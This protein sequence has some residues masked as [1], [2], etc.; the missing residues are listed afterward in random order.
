MAN[1]KYIDDCGGLK[2]VVRP[3]LKGD[4]D[5]TKPMSEQKKTTATKKK[6]KRK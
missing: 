2:P 6:V 1:K 3:R 4:K 5:P